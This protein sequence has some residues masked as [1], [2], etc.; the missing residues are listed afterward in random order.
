MCWLLVFR[1]CVVWSLVSGDRTEGKDLLEAFLTES[2]LC[3]QGT[4]I[5]L[6]FYGI[7]TSC[8]DG[9]E[10]WSWSWSI[11]RC[12]KSLSIYLW[13]QKW[14]WHELTRWVTHWPVTKGRLRAAR[15]GKIQ[16]LS[17]IL[18]AATSVS[19]SPSPP[20]WRGFCLSSWQGSALT[21]GKRWQG[22]A[23]S[24]WWRSW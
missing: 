17:M 14:H 10:S 4:S 11:V 8:G 9:R 13:I 1:S 7:K 18:I 5:S 15:K 24:H 2:F 23:L 3:I 12:L 22:S 16:D 19:P 20:G 21:G 6:F